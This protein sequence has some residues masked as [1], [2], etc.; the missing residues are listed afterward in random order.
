MPN[1]K[2]FRLK[3]VSGSM[4]KLALGKFPRG[5]VRRD[6]KARD[7]LVF[8][9]QRCFCRAGGKIC[10]EREGK[11]ARVFRRTELV[12]QGPAA[13]RSI[14][15]YAVKL[16]VKVPRNFPEFNCLKE[17]YCF[18]ISSF[19]VLS[20]SPIHELRWTTLMDDER[21]F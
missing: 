21:N 17:P 14:Y 1:N 13:S 16:F 20:P 11:K 12:E 3:F 8:R 15:H 10:R 9:H 18:H 4:P 2:L 5:I 6:G 7:N 19:F